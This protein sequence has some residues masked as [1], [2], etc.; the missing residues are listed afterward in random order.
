MV[1]LFLIQP[2]LLDENEAWDGRQFSEKTRITQRDSQLHGTVQ[3]LQ[4]YMSES[5]Q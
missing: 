5:W 3:F 4:Q 1:R 2:R